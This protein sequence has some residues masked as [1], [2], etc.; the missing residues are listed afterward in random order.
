[1]DKGAEI[2]KKEVG[3]RK[4]RRRNCKG[5]YRRKKLVRQRSG[6]E[7]EQGG[8]TGTWKREVGEEDEEEEQEN[9]AGV[10]V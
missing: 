6:L 2:W 5:T 9:G 10:Y 7:G 4:K 1:M 8:A 3:K